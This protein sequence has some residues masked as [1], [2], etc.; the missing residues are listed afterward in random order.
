M[1]ILANI[2]FVQYK[3][4]SIRGGIMFA[5]AFHGCSQNWSQVFW[6]LKIV[7]NVRKILLHSGRLAGVADVHW[8]DVILEGKAC[9]DQQQQPCS[10]NSTKLGTC[11]VVL[12]TRG[13]Y[14]FFVVHTLN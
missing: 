13:S 4:I 1:K 3:K 5:G 11:T 2:C 6:K 8:N 10:T 14:L 9:R 12:Q 7:R